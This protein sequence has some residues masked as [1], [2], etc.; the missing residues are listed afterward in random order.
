MLSPELNSESETDQ[1][2]ESWTPVAQPG[3][4]LVSPVQCTVDKWQCQPVLTE[5]AG[6]TLVVARDRVSF[7]ID[8]KMV[9]STEKA[10][11]SA[12]AML[13]MAHHEHTIQA[14]SR[15]ARLPTWP[16][17]TALM[18]QLGLGVTVGLS[19]FKAPP[20]IPCWSTPTENFEW[21]N[22]Q[23]PLVMLDWIPPEQCLT[24][25]EQCLISSSFTVI[26]RLLALDKES[27][28]WLSYFHSEQ[29]ND[30]EQP[31]VYRSHWWQTRNKALEQ[32]DVLTI[33]FPEQGM[34]LLPLNQ[35]LKQPLP[36]DQPES[37]DA[38][39]YFDNTLSGPYLSS[40]GQHLW[41]DCSMQVLEGA[42]LVGAGVVGYIPDFTHFNFSVGG[43][44]T[45]Q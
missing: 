45:S 18:S 10:S 11:D 3:I 15:G 9:W 35:L 17:I 13:C 24:V 34:D 14:L 28:T 39:S 20:L 2:P 8:D 32:C 6:G 30:K 41:T 26:W 42:Q 7:K 23:A 44:A 37:E 16:W 27:L 25:L 38:H 36:L 22:D 31:F 19:V 40:P 12:A 33:W 29:L 21:D 43:P 1:I 5:V 4:L